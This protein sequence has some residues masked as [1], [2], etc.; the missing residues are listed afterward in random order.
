MTGR[1]RVLVLGLDSVSPAIL[2]TMF[3]SHLPRIHGVVERG[4]MGTLKSCDPPITIP[5][6]AVMFTGMDAGSLGLYGFRNRRAGSYF[7]N[8]SPTPASLPYPAVW[9]VASRVGRRV[10]VIGVPPGYPPP[11]VNGVYVSCLLTPP[12]AQDFVSPSSLSEEMGRVS[13]KYQFDVEFRTDDRARVA[14]ELMEM[15]RQ[16]WTLARHL[17]E[18]EPWDLFIV[19][20]IGTDRLHHAFWKY[21][22]P[23]HRR[24]DAASEFARVAE[25]YYDLLDREVGELL[26]RVG[27]D[28]TIL[29]VSDHG[30]QAMEGCFCI[31]EWLRAQGLLTLAE[32]C[33]PGTPLEKAPVDWARTKAWGAGGYYARIHVNL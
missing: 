10:C 16:R 22:D 8:V 18:K 33:P 17:W 9:D 24:H 7:E 14:A 27:D 11:A 25:Q 13:P 23:G 30:T 29:I 20:E 31:N 5:A 12:G 21:F 26:D 1:P 6:W 32:P 2:S 19:H 3:R 4:A 28:V 15:T